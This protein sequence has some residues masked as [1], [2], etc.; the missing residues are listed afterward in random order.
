MFQEIYRYVPTSQLEIVL[1]PI[2]RSYLFF[3]GDPAHQLQLEELAQHHSKQLLRSI[4]GNTHK[5][6]AVSR[7]S[8]I[9]GTK[10][11]TAK[12]GDL[13]DLK[14]R[15]FAAGHTENEVSEILFA[16]AVGVSAEYSQGL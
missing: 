11:L 13:K 7:R 15:L 2:S 14:S 12:S 1:K 16:I 6:F 3:E 9:F 4:K 10:N 8:S 5:P